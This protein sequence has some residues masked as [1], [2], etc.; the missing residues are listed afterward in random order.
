MSTR[1]LVV[2]A[3]CGT[4]TIASAYALRPGR[5]AV[6]RPGPAIVSGGEGTELDPGDTNGCGGRSK[7]TLTDAGAASV[8]FTPTLDTVAALRVLDPSSAGPGRPRTTPELTTYVV[9]ARLVYAKLEADHDIH[10]VIQDPTTL[11]TMIVEFPDPTCPALVGTPH[12]SEIAAARQAVLRAM[13]GTYAPQLFG[14]AEITGVGFFDLI[15]GQHGVAPNGIEL[16]PATSFRLLTPPSLGLRSWRAQRKRGVLAEHATIRF[17]A[18]RP[19]RYRVIVREHAR[20]AATRTFERTIVQTSRCSSPT[21]SWQFPTSS[22]REHDVTFKVRV[23]GGQ[24]LQV[25]RTK[26]LP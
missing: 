4:A 6:G 22:T 13:G 24:Q 9:T 26:T 21:L 14:T 18:L 19:G 12:A 8:D 7:K 11:G 17:C 2:L 10:L 15:H 16:H 5:A 23:G 3:L 20:N 1:Q 25:S